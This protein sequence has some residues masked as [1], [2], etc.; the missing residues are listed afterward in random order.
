MKYYLLCLDNNK[1]SNPTKISS[2]KLVK[3]I[4]YFD[5][6]NH[7]ESIEL[8]AYE[9]GTFLN[10]Y[11]VDVITGKKIYLNDGTPKPDITYSSKKEVSDSD[12]IRISEIYKNLSNDELLRYKNGLDEIEKTSISNYNKMVENAYLY[13]NKLKSASTFLSSLIKEDY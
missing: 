2:V 3:D 10:S 13:N 7:Y 12:L 8:L 9:T 5:E 11:M 1:C 4:P 6:E